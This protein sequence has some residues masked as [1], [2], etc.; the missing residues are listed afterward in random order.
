MRTATLTVR[1]VW[2]SIV[3][4]MVLMEVVHTSVFSPI[5]YNG[6]EVL[7]IHLDLV[8]AQI[9]LKV[10]LSILVL[11]DIPALDATP[12]Q[13]LEEHCLMDGA[14]VRLLSRIVLM[15]VR[16][17]VLFTR[18]LSMVENVIVVIRLR[19]GLSLHLLLIAA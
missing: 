16:L 3:V 17:R 8:A 4:V 19:M 10:H 5:R 7:A 2:R 14:S 1:E 11:M 6:M 15:L 9:L 13:Q 12:K 18:V